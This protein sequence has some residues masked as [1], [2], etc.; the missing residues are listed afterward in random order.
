[1]LNGHEHTPTFLTNN[2]KITTV[3]TDNIKGDAHKFHGIDEYDG[4]VFILDDDLSVPVSYVSDMTEAIK[5]YGGIVSLHG[6][7]MRDRPI[8][9]WYHGFDKKFMCLSQV[10]NDER[11]DAVGSGIC[12]WDTDYF[13]ITPDYCEEKNMADVW[14][15][16]KAQEEG[17]PMHVL[18]H[19][20]GYLTHRNH[21]YNIYRN[22]HKRRDVR[23]TEIYNNINF[24]VKHAI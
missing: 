12:A 5:R 13:T 23:A 8:H 20:K 21:E 22:E 15:S 4:Y 16:K 11:V 17:K 7:I 10:N 2:P 24:P 6:A 1:M 3:M 14:L 18:R 9:S 19:P